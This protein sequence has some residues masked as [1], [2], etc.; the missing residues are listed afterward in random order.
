MQNRT[1]IIS[2]VRFFKIDHGKILNISLFYSG[3][4]QSR[5]NSKPLLV[6]K[7]IQSIIFEK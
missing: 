5:S 6:Q 7:W 1:I 4:D 2:N 3:G